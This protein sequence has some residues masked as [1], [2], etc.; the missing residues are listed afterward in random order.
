MNG[1]TSASPGVSV[2]EY[3]PSR[4]TTPARACGTIRTVRQSVN[5]TNAATTSTTITATT[6]SLLFVD[7]RRR[8]LDLRHLAPRPGLE[9]LIRHVR[10]CRPLLAADPDT[11]AGGVDALQH[12]RGRADE[13]GGARPDR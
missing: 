8:A 12:D 6:T 5:S 2:R 7:E 3:R 1:T 9:H 13:R 10:A 4:S 11:A